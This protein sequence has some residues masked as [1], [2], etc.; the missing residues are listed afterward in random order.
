[1]P[2]PSRVHGGFRHGQR[3]GGGTA[4]HLPASPAQVQDCKSN[5]QWK[6]HLSRKEQEHGRETE[7]EQP[8]FPFSWSKGQ[9]VG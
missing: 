6:D 1:M 7:Q 5:S 4:K 2:L 9:E 3:R 8:F